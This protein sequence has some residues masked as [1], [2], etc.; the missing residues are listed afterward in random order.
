MSKLVRCFTCDGTGRELEMGEETCPSCVGTGR[1]KTSD[2]WA[3]HCR[4]CNGRGRINYCRRGR[5]CR[6]CNGSRFI[7][8]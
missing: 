2:L 3:E 6:A 1:D 8:I 7:R 5:V 4:Q